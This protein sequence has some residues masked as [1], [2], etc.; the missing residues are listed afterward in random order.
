MIATH[1]E[2][3]RCAFVRCALCGRVA[4]LGG[5]AAQRG[6]HS[7]FILRFVYFCMLD[8]R[9]G[10]TAK[11]SRDLAEGFKKQEVSRQERGGSPL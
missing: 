4:W 9:R 7:W 11:V 3:L 1:R 5:E 2:V 6:E 8:P 10:R